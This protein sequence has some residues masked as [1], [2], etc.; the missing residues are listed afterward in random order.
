VGLSNKAS[1]ILL[2]GTGPTASGSV[3][4]FP[5]NGEMSVLSWDVVNGLRD[6]LKINWEYFS[7]VGK[8]G[9]MND[10]FTSPMWSL[11][12]QQEE[13]LQRTLG[14]HCPEVTGDSYQ[15]HDEEADECYFYHR[16]EE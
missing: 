13:K 5:L 3:E 9:D 14:I 12:R 15:G 4:L 2:F 10:W 6:Q 8:D 16:S 11:L 1:V 7:G